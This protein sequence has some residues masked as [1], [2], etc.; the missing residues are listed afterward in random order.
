MMKDFL[1][2]KRAQGMSTS[3]I[4]LLILGIVI[5]VVLILGFTMGWSRLTP[6]VSTNNIDA[7]KASCNVAC[8]TN[9]QYEYCSVL[10]NVDDGNNPEFEETCYNLANSEDYSD[11]GYG[12]LSCPSIDCSE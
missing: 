6:W 8:S 4:I 3:T 12:I 1:G 7:I 11:R 5:L 2:N 9:A 10:R